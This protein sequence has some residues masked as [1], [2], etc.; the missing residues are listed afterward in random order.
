MEE[1]FNQRVVNP[2]SQKVKILK[3]NWRHFKCLNCGYVQLIQTNHE[4]TCIDYCKNCSWK[5]SFGKK[6][7]AIQMFGHTYRPFEFTT[8]ELTKKE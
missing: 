7:Y 2:F 6:E 8:E 1:N 4:G 3:H 5:P